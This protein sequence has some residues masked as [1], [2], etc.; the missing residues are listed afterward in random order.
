MRMPPLQFNQKCLILVAITSAL[1]Y[2]CA[3][4]LQQTGILLTGVVCALV[5]SLFAILIKLYHPVYKCRASPN[6][7]TVLAWSSLSLVIPA[8][9]YVTLWLQ[10][11]NQGWRLLQLARLFRWFYMVL[12][13]GILFYVLMAQF[14]VMHHCRFQMQPTILSFPTA[15]F[16][17]QKY[18]QS[19]G[20]HLRS[21]AIWSCILYSVLVAVTLPV[22]LLKKFS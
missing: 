1:Y 7:L 12:I 13:L 8:A 20:E 6:A 15:I 18:R 2:G 4:W 19:M 22:A 9:A 11:K 16:K 17:G 21:F 10:P 14:D 3:L 5:W